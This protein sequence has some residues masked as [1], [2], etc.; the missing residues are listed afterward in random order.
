MVKSV[1]TKSADTRSVARAVALQSLFAADMR[2]QVQSEG[3][4]RRP[5]P[6]YEWLDEELDQNTMEFADRLHRG[7]CDHRQGL[8][9]LIGSF[10]P[11]WPVPQ[12]PVVDRNILRIA[13]F[14]LLHNPATPPKAAID[15]AVELAKVFGSDSSARFVNGVLGSVMSSLESGELA[16]A[17]VLPDG[18]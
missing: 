1:E 6:D 15:E 12:L 14:E 8:D 17:G 3:L 16:V 9:A 10:A 2:T 13:I 18:R 5:A 7:V 11:A 4:I